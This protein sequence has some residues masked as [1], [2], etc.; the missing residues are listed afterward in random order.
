MTALPTAIDE[1][2]TI[3]AAT[4][5]DQSYFQ[6]K[7]NQIAALGGEVVAQ[8]NRPCVV[9]YATLD[10]EAVAAVQTGDV[11]ALKP[12]V[13]GSDP[14]VI[15]ANASAIAGGA[16][17]CG[18]VVDAGAPGQRVRIALG[19]LLTHDVTGLGADGYARLD[20][21]GRME[22]V[23]SYSA[24]DY[25]LGRSNTSGDA[26]LDVQG[27][28]MDASGGGGSMAVAGDLLGTGSVLA[29]PRVG[30]L[31]G[32]LGVVSVLAGA[33]LSFGTNPATVGSLRH[34]TTSVLMAARNNTNTAN[35]AVLTAGSANQIIVG[36]D[37]AAGALP[38]LIDFY[39]STSG[40]QF[41]PVG[42]TIRALIGD[43]GT[44]IGP[45]LVVAALT[46]TPVSTIG[47]IRVANGTSILSA[48]NAANTADLALLAT[49]SDIL[50]VGSGA[51]FANSCSQTYV[52]ATS[53]V[54]FAVAGSQRVTVQTSTLTLST[55]VALL[56]GGTVSATGEIRAAH[57]TTIIAAR[58]SANSADVGILAFSH[59]LN[60]ITVGSTHTGVITAERLTLCASDSVI[61]VPGAGGFSV[62][63]SGTRFSVT[64]ALVTCWTT[65]KL[66]ASVLQLQGAVVASTGD[67][68]ASNNTTILAGRN[69]ANSADL[70]LLSLNSSNNLI[71]GGNVSAASGPANTY[72]AAS[73]SVIHFLGGIVTTTTASYFHSTVP[74]IL[75]A[76]TAAAA[77]IGS[78]CA[79]NNT[80]ILAGRNAANSADYSL[81]S[82]NNLNEFI[83][84]GSTAATGTP[85]GGT[86]VVS[87]TN[88]VLFTAGAAVLTA[89]SGVVQLGT[90]VVIKF[91]GTV[92]A[93]GQIRAANATTMVVARN[94]ANTADLA[95][96]STNASNQLILGADNTGGASKATDTLLCCSGTLYFIPASTA[97]SVSNSGWFFNTSLYLGSS[98]GSMPG[99]GSIRA[100]N[101]TTI[102]AARNAANSGD[103]PVIGTDASDGIFLGAASQ[104]VTTGRLKLSEGGAS[105]AFATTGLIRP[106][107]GFTIIAVRNNANSAN[108]SL[109]SSSS[110][111]DAWSLGASAFAQGS[112]D[113]V[114][115]T[116]YQAGTTGINLTA[117]GIALGKDLT[118]NGGAKVLSGTGTPE[119]V[120]FGSVGD[121]FL[122]TNG[123]ASTTLYVKESG[124]GTQT[125]W[126]A[127]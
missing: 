61:V 32:I 34:A 111:S 100:L 11:V 26:Y 35:I 79:P 45:A 66:D 81:L 39:A 67:I 122:R 107:L 44:F 41:R 25:V 118:I 8:R 114:T 30:T 103:L 24:G 113:A 123:G 117:S 14:F 71:V 23:A 65:V 6:E 96:V 110:G 90:S 83:V 78:I 104:L 18:V 2:L 15:L 72:V 121:I 64:N 88:V 116:I 120:V 51:G 63:V 60:W 3:T 126:V 13:A 109:L 95:L 91:S 75:G 33:A 86:F 48:R 21:N 115:V 27:R 43:T 52:A 47:D 38:T 59:A 31:T 19:G 20:A 77:T 5:L 12:S 70:S 10:P 9:V 87:G 36:S 73:S 76:S 99:T 74:I 16:V 56:L 84:G 57:N 98:T 97:G 29:S 124:G 106:E 62:N 46:T 119:G 53:A 17:P 49:T 50:T 127:K 94:A 105:S 37:G 108:L 58:N 92:A 93:T 54:L 125:G 112:I 40:F 68:R 102:I 22:L 4:R 85:A 80:T 55:G 101:N 42:T 7:E 82:L 89:Q 28:P 69:A 1:T